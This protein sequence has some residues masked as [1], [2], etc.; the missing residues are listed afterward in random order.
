MFKVPKPN[1]KTLEFR[2]LNE[3]RWVKLTELH[4]LV[5]EGK[6]PLDEFR[7]LGNAFNEELVAFGGQWG[8][9]ISTFEKIK[10][11]FE[12]MKEHINYINNLSL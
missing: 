11:R 6:Y 7:A 12:S 2:K 8:F 3:Q 9:G 4:M 10:P 5:D 1:E